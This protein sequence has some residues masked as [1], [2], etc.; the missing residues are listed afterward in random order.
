MQNEII[1]NAKSFINV[2]IKSIPWNAMCWSIGFRLFQNQMLFKLFKSMFH[3]LMQLIKNT[4]LPPVLSCGFLAKIV[5]L[6]SFDLIK[7]QDLW[8]TTQSMDGYM[9]W[10]NR[11]YISE[12]LCRD[13]FCDLVGGKYWSTFYNTVKILKNIGRFLLLGLVSISIKVL[14]YDKV[15]IVCFITKF[16]SYGGS[17]TSITLMFVQCLF[18]LFFPIF[19]TG[20]FIKLP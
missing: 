20:K 5:Q 1:L 18:R 10:T 9:Q 13:W 11:C 16:S 19:V 12:D 15:F 2:F 14:Y 6:L 3:H 7:T 4:E 8:W 17:F